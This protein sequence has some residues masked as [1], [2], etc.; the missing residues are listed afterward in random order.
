V[1][2]TARIIP[3]TVNMEEPVILEIVMILIVVAEI[4]TMMGVVVIVHTAL[5]IVQK[6]DVKVR[7]NSCR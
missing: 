6:M 5:G 7:N 4:V 1:V 2:I 3:G